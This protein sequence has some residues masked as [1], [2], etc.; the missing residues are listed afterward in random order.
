M[1]KK[2]LISILT[3]GVL[4]MTGCS[5]DSDSSNDGASNSGSTD[6]G[7]DLSAKTAFEG[8][9]EDTNSSGGISTQTFKGNTLSFS[10][11]IV[12]DEN[13]TGILSIGVIFKVNGTKPIQ[14]NNR[15]ATKVEMVAFNTCSL[16]YTLHTQ[17]YVDKFNNVN[18]CD[19]TWV[20]NQ[21]VDIGYCIYTGETTSG[22]QNIKNGFEDDI[23]KGETKDI[24]YVDGNKLYEGDDDQ[25]ID[26]QGYPEALE[27]DFS[28]RK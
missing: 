17:D 21:T 25:G 26:N 20:L 13:T 9:W 14:P 23:K 12:D 6:N 8:T 3:A 2:L 27:T 28:T 15:T 10:S 11:E 22:C 7:A 18:F 4:L 5:K 1:K 24:L 19:K 16:D